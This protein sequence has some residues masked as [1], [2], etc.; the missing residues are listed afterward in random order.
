MD[1]L[2]RVRADGSLEPVTGRSLEHVPRIYCF[3]HGWAPGSQAAA[4]VI[5][6]QTGDIPRAWD[7]GMVDMFGISLADAYLPLLTAIAASDPQA[8]VVWFSWVDESATDVQV[9]A[10]GQ[11]LAHTQI[12]G[13]RLAVALVGACGGRLPRV[14]LI[15]HSHGSV[16]ATHAALALP[17]A[18]DQLTLLDCPEDWFSRAGGAAGLLSEVL[19]RLEPGRGPGQVLVDSYASLFGRSYHWHPGLSEVVDVRL[20]GGLLRREGR[21]A[22]GDAHEYAV[23]WYAETVATG[24]QRCGFGWSVLAA[25]RSPAGHARDRTF[26]PRALSAGY[27]VSAGRSPV[28]IARRRSTPT[29]PRYQVIPLG[30]GEIELSADRPDVLIA[31]ALP[32]ADL[33]EFDYQISEPGRRSRVEG[34]VQRVLAFTGAAGLIEVPARGRYLRIPDDRDPSAPVLVQFRLAEPDA[35]TTATISGL[36]ALRVGRTRNYDTTRTTVTVAAMGA[37]AGSA[38]TLAVQ[39]L[40]WAIGRRLMKR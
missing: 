23:D 8:A 36:Q 11:S 38:A 34:A 37:I 12:N 2:V 30:V 5:H 16:V 29:Q 9:F 35:T 18:P 21:G 24:D 28:A 39:G 1:R 25:D 20:A 40:A 14:Q 27:V 26:D 3:V 13:W 33:L 15:G 4:H 17:S 31:V 32:D 10:A 6:A 22:A 19:P 7:A